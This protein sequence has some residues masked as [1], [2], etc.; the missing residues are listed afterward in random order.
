MAWGGGAKAFADMYANNA[1]FLDG[2][3]KQETSVGIP[4]FKRQP[5]LI[6]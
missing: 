5:N 6:C 4:H 2:T 1:S 3:P